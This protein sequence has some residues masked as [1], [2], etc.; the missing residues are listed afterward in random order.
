MLRF[1][2]Q[3]MIDGNCDLD[4]F[5][6]PFFMHFPSPVEMRPWYPGSG[7]PQ[8]NILNLISVLTRLDSSE[9]CRDQFRSRIEDHP[10]SSIARLSNLFILK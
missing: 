9:P 5:L 8:K 6:D 2:L 1:I 3:G 7:D 4:L 10:G